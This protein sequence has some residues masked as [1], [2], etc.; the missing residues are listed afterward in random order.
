[1][2]TGEVLPQPKQVRGIEDPHRDAALPQPAPVAPPGADRSHP[3]GQDPHR[4][5]GPGPLDQG[6][7]KQHP[8]LVA[9]DDVVVEVHPAAGRGDALQHRGIDLGSIVEQGD[10]VAGHRAAAGR[11]VHGPIDDFRSGLVLGDR[12]NGHW[13]PSPRVR[14]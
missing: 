8:G 13:G 12:P 9:S 1:M 4:D 14:S 5:P 10:P 6:V 11:A 2:V 7:G 3:V